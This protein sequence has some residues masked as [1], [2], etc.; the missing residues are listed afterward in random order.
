MERTVLTEVYILDVLR[1]PS[2][3]AWWDLGMDYGVYFFFF[4]EWHHRN[5]N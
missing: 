3:H 4:K 2:G 1:I 5:R